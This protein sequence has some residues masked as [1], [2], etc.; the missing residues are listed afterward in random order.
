MAIAWHRIDGGVLDDL[1]GDGP[2]LP[3][4]G[5]RYAVET[6]IGRGGQG[7]VYRAVDLHFDCPVAI[8]IAHRAGP[9]PA[10][11]AEGRLLGRLDHPAIPAPREYGRTGDGRAY[12]VL[13]LASG[14]PLQRWLGN[15]PPRALRLAVFRAIVAAVGHAHLR[16]LV[17]RDLKPDNIRVADDGSAWV[18]DWGLAADLGTAAVCGSPIYAAPE[19][20][21]GQGVDGRCDIYSLGVLLYQLLSGRLPF[22]GEIGDFEDFRR[23]RAGM[24]RLPLVK[25]ARGVGR[26]LTELVERCLA[27]QPLT[28]PAQCRELLAVLDRRERRHAGPGWWPMA[29]ACTACLALGAGL[30]A[31]SSDERRAERR[32]EEL[33][34]GRSLP[35]S[36]PEGAREGPLED[37]ELPEPPPPPAS[38]SN[39]ATEA[40]LP[41]DANNPAV[42]SQPDT[43]SATGGP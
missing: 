9:A 42:G 32:L 12:L 3:D 10:L 16:G 27:T 35:W 4:L 8:K 41:P 2:L 23:R 7:E 38:G 31:L 36:P 40:A 21:A 22:V 30:M 33:G 17:H 20:L 5:E 34:R 14:E 13:S 1:L 15:H 26:E 11:E 24:R 37:S 43:A 25:A 28:R 29:A 19:Q 18:V 6:L 39:G